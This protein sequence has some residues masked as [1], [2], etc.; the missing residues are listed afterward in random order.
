MNLFLHVLFIAEYGVDSP[1][2][3]DIALLYLSENLEWTPQVRPIC[4]SH[5]PLP[6]VSDSL[7]C[8]SAGW[9]STE[10]IRKK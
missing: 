10:N 8:H 2:L 1:Y 4:L 6:D 9:G 7:T 3:N 5:S